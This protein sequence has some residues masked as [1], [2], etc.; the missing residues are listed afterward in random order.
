MTVRE[1]LG[2][3]EAVPVIRQKLQTLD[4]VGLDYIRLVRR[5]PPCWR[6]GRSTVEARDRI[7]AAR[8]GTTRSTSSTSRRPPSLRGHPRSCSKC[9]PPRRSRQHGRDHRAQPR[10]D[11]TGDVSRSRPRGERTRR[12]G[13]I[14]AG[15]PAVATVPT[16]YTGSSSRRSESQ[17]TAMSRHGPERTRERCA[18]SRPQ[19]SAIR[20][21]MRRTRISA[22]SSSSSS[23]DDLD[24]LVKAGM[25]VARLT[26]RTARTRSTRT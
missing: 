20:S 11:Q 19:R 23:V 22:R 25:D 5:R 16:S 4:D 18:P 7:V 12:S 10:C 14:A 21:A 15:T 3:F 8:H 24:R 9:E 26:S 13:V 2:F 6:R 17:V 1:G